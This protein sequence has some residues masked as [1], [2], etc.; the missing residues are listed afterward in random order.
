MS[1]TGVFVLNSIRPGKLFAIFTYHLPTK[2]SF[3]KIT[4]G[5]ESVEPV[6]ISTPAEV[7]IL[8]LITLVILALLSGVAVVVVLVAALGTVLGT[9]AFSPAFAAV[10]VPVL[11]AAF[12]PGGLGL[13]L[14]F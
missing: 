11:V 5:V 14:V 13:G 12:G 10:L 2:S 7:V 1:E 4:F 6:F 9:A 8:G 3:F